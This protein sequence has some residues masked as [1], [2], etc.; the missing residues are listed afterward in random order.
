MKRRFHSLHAV[1]R[2]LP[3]ALYGLRLSVGL[4]GCPKRRKILWVESL[5]ANLMFVAS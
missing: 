5:E 1:A 3:D 4:P 2:E